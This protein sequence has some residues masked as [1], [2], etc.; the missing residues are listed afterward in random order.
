MI[1]VGDLTQFSVLDGD[2]LAPFPS[3]RP[4]TVRLTFNAPQRTVVNVVP[5]F[6]DGT[7]PEDEEPMFLAVVEG[8]EEVEFYAMGAFALSIE[9]DRIWFKTVDGKEVHSVVPDAETF[10][11]IATRRVRNPE[12]EA[13]QHML[14]KNQERRM[15]PVYE[16]LARLRQENISA[17][18]AANNTG[19]SAPSGNSPS[20]EPAAGGGVTT[21]SPAPAPSGEAAK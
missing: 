16:E 7:F 3:D 10:T 21:P 11:R 8:L 1:R 14:L 20:P 2:K 4:R 17:R 5:M 13:L 15:G 9:A 19:A 12:V 6:A 18:A